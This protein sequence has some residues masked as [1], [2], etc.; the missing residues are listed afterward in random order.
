MRQLEAFC[1]VIDHQTVTGA[2]HAMRLSQPAV[3]KLVAT[4]EQDTRLALFR[5]DR[6]RLIPTEEGLILHRQAQAIFD[7]LHDIERLSEE[8]RNLAGGRLNVVT[9]MALGRTFLPDAMSAFLRERPAVVASLHVRSSRT[10]VDQIAAQQADLGFT[11]LASDDPGVSA[12]V[13]CRLKGVCVLP[14]AHPLAASPVIRAR[15]LDGERFISFSL[16]SSMRRRIDEVFEREGVA[17]QLMVDAYVSAAACSFVANGMGVAIVEPFTAWDFA[18]SGQVVSRPFEPEVVFEFRML[19][20]A[21]RP[22]SLLAEAFAAQVERM[23]AEHVRRTG[24]ETVTV[25]ADVRAATEHSR[26]RIAP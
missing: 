3:S 18:R 7:R 26:R 12:R 24:A 17:R 4:L 22:P 1:A 10:V 14:P 13:L 19:R 25:P 8:L 20:P 11:M 5:R 21:G 2:A 16:D 23:L 9:M 15:D 6:R